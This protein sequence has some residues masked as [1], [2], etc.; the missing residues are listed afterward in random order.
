MPLAI[1]NFEVLVG[2]SL[3]PVQGPS[4]WHPFPSSV[5]T[6]L[7]SSLSFTNLL[8]QS[9]TKML[10]KP[11]P[12]PDPQGAPVVFIWVLSHLL[13]LLNATIQPIPYPQSDSSVTSISFHFRDSDIIWD[14]VKCYAQVQVDDSSCFSLIYQCCNP[15]M[16][17]HQICQALFSLSETIWLSPITSQLSMCMISRRICSMTLLV[18]E[19]RLAC[20]SLG[21]FFFSFC[22]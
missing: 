5:L 19:V 22:L 10:N 2:A 7:P 1:V 3:E 14:C 15:V 4:G 6:V 16:E 9:L 21:W 18:T 8:S 20:S 17:E 11:G 13:Q 12:N